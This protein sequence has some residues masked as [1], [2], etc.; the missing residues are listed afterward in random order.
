[1]YYDTVA[2]MQIVRISRVSQ[3]QHYNWC[4]GS[5]TQSSG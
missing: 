3:Q 2:P 4:T 5:I 1:V